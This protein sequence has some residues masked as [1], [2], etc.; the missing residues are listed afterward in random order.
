MS[1]NQQRKPHICLP[2][3]E[4]LKR[5]GLVT[6]V[7]VP[8]QIEVIKKDVIN[9]KYGDVAFKIECELEGVTKRLHISTRGNVIRFKLLNRGEGREEEDILADTLAN[10]GL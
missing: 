2:I 10:L 6:I 4:E 1:R 9:E 8:S 3:W 5:T 7:S